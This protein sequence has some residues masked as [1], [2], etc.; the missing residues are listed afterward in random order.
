MWTK[1]DVFFNPF[2]SLKETFN[3]IK[4][5]MKL[6]ENM[7][8]VG[9]KSVK[10][11]WEWTIWSRNQRIRNFEKEKK[12]LKKDSRIKTYENC[13]YSLKKKNTLN[14]HIR[15]NHEAQQCNKYKEKVPLHSGFA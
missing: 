4:E 8:W 1:K 6:K 14:N 2:L 7:M 13:D 11:N 12:F 9:N 15:K 10:K 5:A 3:P